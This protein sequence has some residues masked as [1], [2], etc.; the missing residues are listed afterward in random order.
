MSTMEAT[1]AEIESPR[2]SVAV[3]LASDLRTFLRAVERH[4]CVQALGVH[5]SP[6][7]LAAIS[8]RARAL[9]GSEADDAYEHPADAASKGP[10]R[11]RMPT[12]GCR[13]REVTFGPSLALGCV[14]GLP[15]I[16]EQRRNS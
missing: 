12:G 10:R 7:D 15:G 13:G 11:F 14:S 3:N 4:S 2:S 1:L 6:G 16:V 5:L 8:G 9:V